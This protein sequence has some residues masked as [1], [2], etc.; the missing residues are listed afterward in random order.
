MG[1]PATNAAFRL[2]VVLFND[3]GTYRLAVINP[4]GDSSLF[5]LVEANLNSSL[6]PG[7]GSGIDSSGVFYSAVA[8]TSKFMRIV[9]WLDFSSGLATLGLWSVAPDI[10]RMFCPNNQKPG[11]QVISV[12]YNDL[13][14][15][16]TTNVIPAD[17]TIPQSSEGV[18]VYS[19]VNI[20]PASP[21][22]IM[23]FEVVVNCSHSVAGLVCLA[24]FVGSDTDASAVAW[25]YVP[26][27]NAQI[28]ITLA[29]RA[30]ARNAGPFNYLVRGG[31]TLAGTFTYNS[32]ALFG[33]KVRTFARLREL[34]A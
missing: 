15:V 6:V 32:S 12:A 27:A 23:E 19:I 26:A 17:N 4:T 14:V 30:R 13:T 31:G 21:A 24:L 16:T 25:G 9:G 2:W 5:P 29:F 28:Q 22:N 11:E 18:Q 33:G 8:V 20:I 10:I 3:S 34:V 1:V 7:G